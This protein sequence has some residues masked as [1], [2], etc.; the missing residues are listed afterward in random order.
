[1]VQLFPRYPPQRGET[2]Q[3]PSEHEENIKDSNP[4]EPEGL[5][6]FSK[7]AWTVCMCGII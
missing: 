7:Q 1:M 2:P 5:T 3:I 6:V 4:S